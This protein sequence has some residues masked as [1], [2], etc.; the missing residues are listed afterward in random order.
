MILIEDLFDRA[1]FPPYLY[2]IPIF[3]YFP[4]GCSLAIIR[5]F[6][7][8]Q[9]LLLS[10]LL[11]KV[12]SIRC[13]LLRIMC[14][15]LGFIVFTEGYEN[16]DNQIKIIIMNH[17][18]NFDHLAF[19]LILPVAV[20]SVWD[21]PQHLN[22]TLGYT[23][24]GASEGRQVFIKNV[25]NFIKDANVPVLIFP[26]GATTN[27][28]KGLLKFN[29]WPFLLNHDIQPVT[30]RVSR[31]VIARISLSIV[32]SRWWSDMLWFLF[33]PYTIFR[34]RFLPVQC[35]KDFDT[36]EDFCESVQE[37]ICQELALEKTYY[38]SADKVEYAKTILQSD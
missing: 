12:P 10:M 8:I 15:V 24:F 37:S 13:F 25:R 18:T 4:M 2:C 36:S 32:G 7:G 34:I 38:T 9:A 14:M 20:P 27:S 31:P 16:S 19:N 29:S 23:Y 35:K 17:V 21:L 33:V 28:K 11:S 26:E 22:W 5:I 3:F 30:L 6:I 1:R